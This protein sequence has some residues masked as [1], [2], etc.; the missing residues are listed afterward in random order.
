M[1]ENTKAGF[2]ICFL[3]LDRIYFAQWKHFEKPAVVRIM[4]I[5]VLKTTPSFPGNRKQENTYS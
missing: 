3:A 1:L 2:Q 5:T 4:F